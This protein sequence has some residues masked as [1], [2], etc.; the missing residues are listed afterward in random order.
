MFNEFFF[1]K[2]SYKNSV[3]LCSIIMKRNM[4]IKTKILMKYANFGTQSEENV[5]ATLRQIVVM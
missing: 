4:L 3:G 1:L 5:C 2:D